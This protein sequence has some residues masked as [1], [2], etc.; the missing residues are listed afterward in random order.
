[1]FVLFLRNSW[2]GVGPL[3]DSWHLPIL[4]R[5]HWRWQQIGH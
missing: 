5:W 2:S 3:A 4:G 1:M